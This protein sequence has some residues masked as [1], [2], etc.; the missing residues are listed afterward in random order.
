MHNPASNNK[1][2]HGVKHIAM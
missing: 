2:S 1:H